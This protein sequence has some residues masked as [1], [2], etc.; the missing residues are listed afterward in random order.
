[1]NV[2]IDV[3]TSMTKAVVFGH[4]GDVLTRR[5]VPTTLLHPAPGHYE[6][7]VERLAESVLGLLRE[8]PGREIELIALTGQGDGLWLVDEQ[9]RGVRP[10]L[11][12]LDARGAPVCESWSESG[13]LD[14][15][16]SR[17]R[18]APFPGAGGA[19]LAALEQTDPN[20]L[21]TARTA[22]QCQHVLFERLTGIRT[23]TRSCAMLPV[24]DPTAGD[25]DDEALR[26]TG[27]ARRR[28]L[29]PE[30]AEASSVIAP[31]TDRLAD[32]LGLARGVRVATGPYDL[33]AAALGIGSL[34]VG[35]G[36]LILG[37]TLACQVVVD[38]VGP[39]DPP[40]GLTLCSGDDR[41]WLR[42]MPAMVGT[43]CLDW[44]LDLVKADHED[45]GRL[46]AG[47]APGANGVAALPF[48]SPAGERAPF[49]DSAARAEFTGLSLDTTAADIVRAVC[50][51]LAYAARH[52]FEAAGLSGDVVV[53]GGGTASPELLQLLADVLERPLAVAGKEEPA[54]RGAVTAANVAMGGDPSPPAV[55]PFVR[56][57]QGQRYT[58]GYVGYLHR[59][60]VA[61][62]HRWWRGVSSS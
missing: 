41:G 13:T 27:L 24:F 7:D 22:T 35:D 45:L 60:A 34:A 57:R 26:L 61:R 6:H 16:F 59:V 52:C 54:A 3:G 19:L 36:L 32:E 20:A 1:M 23:A 14:A 53:C 21:D 29:L 56:P 62:R 10:A 25:Y 50:E 11:S 9:A 55:R 38:R 39:N 17:T 37:T 5:S 48:L 8:L 43:A 51:A 44:V 58:E 15:V 4:T 30:I 31:L 40:V 47:S 42:A 46:L 33:P 12:W 2:G 28:D 18:N 49:A